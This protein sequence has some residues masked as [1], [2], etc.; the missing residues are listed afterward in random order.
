MPESYRPDVLE[1]KRVSDIL[2]A[3]DQTLF[4]VDGKTSIGDVKLLLADE[5]AQPIAKFIAVLNEKGFEGLIELKAL[6]ESEA[7][8][9]PINELIDEKLYSVYEDNSLD[10]ALEF[11]L[12]SGQ[13]V[14]PV[15]DRGRNFVGIITDRDILNAFEKRFIEDRHLHQHISIR[16]KAVEAFN[17]LRAPQEFKK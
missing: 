4:S 6:Q 15:L 2:S 11:M 13:K 17:K 9:Q 3:K 5:N 14:L 10:I 12:K 7:H 16:K 8:T 1:L